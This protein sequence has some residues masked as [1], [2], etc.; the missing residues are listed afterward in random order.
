MINQ[1]EKERKSEVKSDCKIGQKKWN[2]EYLKST[3][4]YLK[5]PDEFND[6]NEPN[7]S[8]TDAN[9]E[10]EAVDDTQTDEQN[11]KVVSIDVTKAL[12]LLGFDKWSSLEPGS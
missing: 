3:S 8:L 12:L 2:E 11:I 7:S 9:K 5:I 6:V 10:E 1:E 4:E